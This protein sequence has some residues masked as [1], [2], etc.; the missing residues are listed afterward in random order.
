M[1]QSNRITYLSVYHIQR[2]KERMQIINFP[3]KK[4][5][6]RCSHGV[7]L[8]YHSTKRRPLNP[9]TSG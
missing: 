6:S 7:S 9:Q 2:V 5:N 8:S 1:S 4:E 3:E